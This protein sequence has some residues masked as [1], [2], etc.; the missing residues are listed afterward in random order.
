MGTA[1]AVDTVD[2]LERLCTIPG[3][4]GGEGRRARALHG[5]LAPLADR[6]A[7]DA[8]GNLAAVKEGRGRGP[9]VLLAAHMDEVGFLV[10]RVE[11]D[12]RVRFAPVGFI[13]PK[14]LAGQAVVVYDPADDGA[15]DI[16]GTIQGKPFIFQGDAAKG[17]A[18]A[19]GDLHIDVGASSRQAVLDLGIKVG[20]LAAFQRCFLRARRSQCFMGTGLDNVTGVAAMVEALKNLQE[21]AGT[22]L[23][24]ATAQEEVGLRGARVTGF[25]AGA[26]FCVCI[27]VSPATDVDE[28]NMPRDASSV[29]LG[30]GAAVTVMDKGALVDR[31]TLDLVEEV[32][33]RAGVRVQ[34]VARDAGRTDAAEIGLSRDGIRTVSIGVPLRYLHTPGEV[35][36]ANDQEAV[37]R[38]VTELVATLQRA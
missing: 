13:D 27:D 31:R 23:A 16:P 37:V 28:D 20:S 25:S 2:T 19:V 10:T 18:F 6:V 38:L 34:R 26:E 21:P 1:D 9:T 36:A 32:A 14:V 33:A 17:H 30:D 5:L 11:N 22:V 4:S 8:L 35:V 24:V 12:G 29:R 7:V 3:V 15:N